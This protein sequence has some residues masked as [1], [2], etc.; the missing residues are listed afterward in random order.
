MRGLLRKDLYYLARYARVYLPWALFLCLITGPAGGAYALMLAIALPRSTVAADERRWDR[1]AAAL[2]CGVDRIVGGKYLLC[3]LC[4]AVGAALTAASFRM[5][6]A[7]GAVI[8]E[9]LGRRAVALSIGRRDILIYTLL[10]LGLTALA[11]ALALPLYYRFGVR[12]GQIWVNLLVMGFLLTAGIWLLNA[13][14]PLPPW[15]QGA[16]IG[17]LLAL[18]AAALA[19]SFRLSVRFYRRRVRGVYSQPTGGA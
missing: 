14:Y 18:D 19:L 9:I 5:T 13:L 4:A 11:A 6:A 15:E 16:A 12:R 10:E 2:P 17:A 3:G 7:A 8:R 1:Y